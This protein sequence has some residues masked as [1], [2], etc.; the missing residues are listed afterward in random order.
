MG[1]LLMSRERGET[2]WQCDLT[3]GHGVLP[4]TGSHSVMLM[5]Q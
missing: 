1:V 5:S 3:Y 2:Y 4:A